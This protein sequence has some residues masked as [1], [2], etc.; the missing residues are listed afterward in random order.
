MPASADSGADL[1]ANIKDP[2]AVNAQ[3]VCPGYKAAQLHEDARGLS[4]VLTLAGEPCHMYGND[5][6]VLNLRVEYQAENRLAVNISP[7]YL[8]GDV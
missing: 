6:D 8:V 2:D 7:A 1:I 3:E 5:V 4:A